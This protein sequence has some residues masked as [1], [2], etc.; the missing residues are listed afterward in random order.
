MGFEENKAFK[1]INLTCA[2]LLNAVRASYGT[3]SFVDSF[4][5]SFQNGIEIIGLLHKCRIMRIC[6]N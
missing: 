6:K 1:W 5:V 2:R 3:K 4:L